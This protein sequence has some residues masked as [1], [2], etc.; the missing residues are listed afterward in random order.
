MLVR[1][2]HPKHGFHICYTQQEVEYH[3]KLGWAVENEAQK[4]QERPTLT[5]KKRGRPKVNHGL[6]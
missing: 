6:I 2:S 5:L 4:E 3:K 1:M